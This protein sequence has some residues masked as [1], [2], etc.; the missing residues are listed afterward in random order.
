MKMSAVT[1]TEPSAVK[2]LQS[3]HW[4]DAEPVVQGRPAK[5]G[6]TPPCFGEDV[7]DLSGILFRVNA[8]A[9]EA[10]ADFRVFESD[11]RRLT[12]KELIMGRLNAR[13]LSAR[14]QRPL[15]QIGATTAVTSV[16]NLRIVGRFLVSQKLLSFSHLRQEHLD[17]AAREFSG[18]GFDP[19]YVAGILREFNFIH[20]LS[21]FL[22]Y[23]GIGFLPWNGVSTR[24]LLGIR[25]REENTTPR[26]PE[27]V[28]G[29]LLTWALAYVERFSDDIL[30]A[31][32]RED[33]GA[34][35]NSSE[36][37][38][39]PAARMRDWLDR[40]V[41]LGAS[42]PLT[43]SGRWAGRVN[44]VQVCQMAG[45]DNLP[46]H[47]IP[48][49]EAAVQKVGLGTAHLYSPVVP[50]DETGEPWR[51]NLD[52]MGI[53][54]EARH[55]MSACYIV[56]AY[57]SGMRD[58]EIQELRA[59]CREVVRDADG[60]VVRHKLRGTTF[61]GKR[62][63]VG[64]IRTW[65]VIE[66]VH[67]AVDVLERLTA[68]RRQSVE[69]GL[70]FIRL[71]GGAKEPALKNTI[72]RRIASLIRHINGDLAPTLNVPSLP[73]IPEPPCPITTRQFRRTIAWHIANRPF[74]VVAGMMQYGHTSE[75]VFEGYAGS[76]Q[77]GFRA[78]VEAERAFARQN[79][80][81]EMYEDFKRGIVPAGAMA[82]E[83]AG[84]F[85][86]VRDV[87]GDLPGKVVDA[88]RRDKMLKHLGTVLYPGLMADCFF[89]A[90]RAVCKSGQDDGGRDVPGI[91]IC[92]PRCRNACWLRK[93]LPA[94]E[95]ALEDAERLGRRNRISPLQ[96]RVVQG[97]AAD[98]AAVVAQI[99][100]A[101][102]C[103]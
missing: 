86:H 63:A 99:K 52:A 66:P 56:C 17:T 61:K 59:G 18:L 43:I 12:A 50:I 29:P 34:P 48:M 19:A 72:N 6:W 75:I 68:R 67:R 90:S 57:L 15:I 77:S 31:S 98:Y 16:S 37:I 23:D 60:E 44:F 33:V 42:L 54:D 38:R 101:Q 94:W 20:D 65:V 35:I 4:D 97:R 10:I 89:D 95:N 91:G 27:E 47:L 74:G 76:S 71:I 85:R 5:D 25:R 102:Q 69:T 92:D 8:T 55:L 51:G 28:I 53:I 24:K 14:G 96:R 40:Q 21:P 11:E 45:I 100:E 46:R 81:I 82:T 70:L 83:L 49:I 2:R 79:D 103:P 3:A 39:K 78:E 13:R 80:V 88:R 58:S 9:A 41:S 22:T 93:H 73:P 7:W 87:L 1:Q 32:R 84:E 26:I 64:A 30:A 36:D 62:L